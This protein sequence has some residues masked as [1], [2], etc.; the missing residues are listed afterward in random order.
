MWMENYN[1]QLIK[2]KESMTRRSKE[3]GAKNISSGKLKEPY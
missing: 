3:E 2:D 1:K